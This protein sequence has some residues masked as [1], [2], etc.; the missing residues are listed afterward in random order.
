MIKYKNEQIKGKERKAHS[1]ILKR[2]GDKHLALIT[3]GL[4][5]PK[6][7]AA[8]N[9]LSVSPSS[10]RICDSSA[11]CKTL[12]KQ[13]AIT[14]SCI[15]DPIICLKFPLKCTSLPSGCVCVCVCVCLRPS[16]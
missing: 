15:N 8:A 7:G 13:T 3:G 4:S 12:A 14:E 11:F 10:T 2:T 5:A 16:F 9:N 1:E 6:Q